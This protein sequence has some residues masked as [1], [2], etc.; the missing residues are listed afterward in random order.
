MREVALRIL[1][2]NGYRVLEAANA[3][4]ALAILA[5]QACDLLL[6][7]VVM[8]Q[9]SGRELV[10][11]THKRLPGLPVL[12]MSGYSQGIFG[13][14]RALDD[15]VALIQKPFGEQDLL[16]KVRATLAAGKSSSAKLHSDRQIER[17]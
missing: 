2:R 1:R 5:D 9:M 15:S 16:E 10:E 7:D 14:H 8:P 12:Y 13:P 17:Q 4:A 3:P 11:Q 6:T